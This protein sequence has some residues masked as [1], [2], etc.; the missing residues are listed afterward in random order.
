ML[1]PVIKNCN[2]KIEKKPP[3]KPNHAT[4]RRNLLRQQ[5]KRA[6][7]C[8]RLWFTPRLTGMKANAFSDVL[9]DRSILDK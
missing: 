2:I 3:G 8:V 5:V 7:G 9:T 1:C 6:N 4:V